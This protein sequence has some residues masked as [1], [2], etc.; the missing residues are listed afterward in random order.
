MAPLLKESQKRK[1]DY[2]LLHTNQH[3][4][5]R[6]DKIFF[7]D[8]RLGP[9]RY[10]LGVG[11]G[12]HGKTTGE[13]I[14]R[15]E[16]ILLKEQPTHVFVLGD[17]NTTLAGAI[18][19]SKI[20]SIALCHVESGL[21]SLDR[22]MPEEINRIVTDHCSDVLFCPSRQQY[23][24]LVAE[25]INQRKLFITGNTIVDTVKY[26]QSLLKQLPDDT[27]KQL[28][29]KSDFILLTCH[30]P[31][32]TDNIDSLK[33]IISAV[34]KI[35]RINKLICLFPVHP[36]TKKLIK[37]YSL[38]L[39]ST[40]EVVPPVGYL[41]MIY[42]QIQSQMILTDSGGLQEEASILKKKCLILRL[43]TERPEVLTTGG[44]LLLEKITQAEIIHRYD[45]LKGQTTHWRNLFGDGHAA[46]KIL[47]IV[48]KMS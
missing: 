47:D 42:L 5:D 23:R 3:Y 32:N 6:L 4:D 16:D 14:I 33:A 37:Y 27:F 43:N 1:H 2:F 11:S 46:E 13:M 9:P 39:P 10:N 12:T 30:R 45:Q 35:S 29:P 38:K 41:Q 22:E 24:N 15:I 25:S 36:R 7:Q 44:A 21:R 26:C 40:I 8:L 28:R 20:N 34:D 48:T 18:A 19:T 31:S 17:T